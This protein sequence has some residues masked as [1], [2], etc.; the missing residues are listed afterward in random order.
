MNSSTLRERSNYYT[1][2]SNGKKK[3]HL[4]RMKVKENCLFVSALVLAITIVCQICVIHT[5]ISQTT[6]TEYSISTFMASETQSVSD[7]EVKT[8]AVDLDKKDIHNLK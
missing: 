7:G 5:G 1:V 6:G 8:D 3:N 2:E 4:T